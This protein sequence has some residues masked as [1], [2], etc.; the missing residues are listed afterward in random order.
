MFVNF[1]AYVNYL[2]QPLSLNSS[3]ILPQLFR[4]FLSVQMR[5]ALKHLQCFVATDTGNLQ[6][7]KITALRQSGQRLM[8]QIVESIVA[9]FCAPYSSDKS[10]VKG[11]AL[12]LE[13][14]ASVDR[15]RQAVEDCY[16]LTGQRHSSVISV[17]CLT[18]QSHSALFVYVF[19]IQIKQLSLSRSQRDSKLH[20][21]PQVTIFACL[22]LRLQPFPLLFSEATVAPRTVLWHTDFSHG[23]TARQVYAFLNFGITKEATEHAQLLLDGAT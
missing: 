18:Q 20:A 21:G 1:R 11:H 2:L 12:K 3:R 4:Q 14:F 6:H 17:F 7:C 9:D 8:S 13:Y 23:I 16:R 5:I 22:A 10:M 15:N 19:P